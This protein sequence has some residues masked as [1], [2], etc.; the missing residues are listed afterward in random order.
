MAIL[1]AIQPRSTISE[2]VLDYCFPP[3]IESTIFDATAVA[4]TL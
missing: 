1:M 4:D 2:P 3:N